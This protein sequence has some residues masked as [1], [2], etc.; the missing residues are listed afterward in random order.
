METVRCD[1]MEHLKELASKIQYRDWVVHVKE[2]Q[3]GNLC[4]Q[5]EAKVIDSVSG[6]LMSNF[7]PSHKVRPGMDDNAVVG[8]IFHMIKESE[9]HEIAETFYFDGAKIFDPHMCFAFADEDLERVADLKG[10]TRN[11]NGCDFFSNDILE[12]GPF[13]GERAEYFKR[14]LLRRIE[15]SYLTVVYLS[16]NTAMDQWTEWKVEQSIALGKRVIAIYTGDSIPTPQPQFIERY[17]IRV[18]PWAQLKKEIGIP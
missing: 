12:K 7:G 1:E 10:Q 4:V 11:D 8:L 6:G 18:L 15:N 3:S 17:H 5:I 14:R 2:S 9:M 16:A 13:D